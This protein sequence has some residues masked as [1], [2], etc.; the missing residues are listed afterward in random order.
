MDQTDVDQILETTK[1]NSVSS[2]SGKTMIALARQPHGTSPRLGTQDVFP[3][4][5]TVGFSKLGTGFVAF[6]QTVRKT[7]R[8]NFSIDNDGTRRV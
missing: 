1:I 8:R 6:S 2:S 7:L 3:R 5:T 4:Q